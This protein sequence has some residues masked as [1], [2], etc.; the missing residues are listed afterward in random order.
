MPVVAV[1]AAVATFVEGVSAIAAATTIAGEVI[2][3]AMAIGGALT[4]AG[5]VTHNANLVK[6]GA[7]LS[8]VGGIGAFAESALSDTAAATIDSTVV[9]AG[10]ADSAAAAEQVAT[11]TAGG[12]G[13][14]DLSAA[15]AATP[16]PPGTPPPTTSPPGGLLASGTDQVGPG[17]AATGDGITGSVAPT[18]P[19]PTTETPPPSPASTTSSAPSSF[20]TSTP[21]TSSS[22]TPSSQNA[23]T[24]PTPAQITEQ[25]VADMDTGGLTPTGTPAA[26]GSSTGYFDSMGRWIRQNPELAR[27]GF[28]GVGLLASSLVPRPLN[29][30]DRS[31]M[32]AI[33]QQSQIDA[34]RAGLAP[35]WWYGPSHG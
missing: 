26:A 23:F 31:R 9:G 5:T 19:A 15:A 24:T 11:S 25:N 33:N 8:I 1:V 2:G 21:S 10:D 6:W 4:L 34:M 32:N 7:A 30:L 12:S 16:P 29:A 17:S 22:F 27:A 13:A 18:T 3:G 20:N 28:Q 14:S 35:G